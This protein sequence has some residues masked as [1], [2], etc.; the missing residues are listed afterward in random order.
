MQILLM[1]DKYYM[2][3]TGSVVAP[4]YREITVEHRARIDEI[5]SVSRRE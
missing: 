3:P 5:R 4:N 1:P 2:K